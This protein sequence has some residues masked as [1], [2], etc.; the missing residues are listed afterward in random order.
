[1]ASAAWP[2]RSTPSCPSSL[3]PS[4]IETD[5]PDAPRTEIS[6]T[7]DMSAVETLP[8][9]VMDTCGP[10][11]EGG[12]LEGGRLTGGRLCGGRL[13]AG[14]TVTAAA[15]ETLPFTWPSPAYTVLMWWLPFA[16]EVVSLATPCALSQAVPSTVLPSLNVT[17]PAGVA[18]ACTAS[19]AAVSVSRWPGCTAWAETLRVVVVD[20][21]AGA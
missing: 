17:V 5:P 8:T 7:R 18:D 21:F 19:T 3:P 2:L 4:R 16:R 14:V 12:G 10:P 1:M 20:A 6:N 9:S 11:L 15:A 13:V